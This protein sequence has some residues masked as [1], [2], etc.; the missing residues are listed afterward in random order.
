MIKL[1]DEIASVNNLGDV[2]YD[3]DQ[4]YL[5][6]NEKKQAQE[7]IGDFNDVFK[8]IE[9]VALSNIPIAEKSVRFS[10]D[11]LNYDPTTFVVPGRTMHGT[12]KKL[13]G[14]YA[15]VWDYIVSEGT[16]LESDFARADG[17]P[18]GGALLYNYTGKI[19]ASNL[20]GITDIRSF[21]YG[22]VGLTEVWEFDTSDVV[23]FFRAFSNCKKLK[24][25]P[26]TLNVSSATSANS[27][28]AQL[29][30]NCASL[31][32]GPTLDFGD[33]TAT[34][35]QAHYLF[36]GCTSMT[37][38]E[39][40][41]SHFSVMHG[42]FENDLSLS[43]CKLTNT[44]NV[45]NFKQCFHYCTSLTEVPVKDM[46]AATDVESMYSGYKYTSDTAFTFVVPMHIKAIPSDLIFNS[47]AVN[48]GAMFAG[49]HD[50]T[51]IPN[52]TWP[53]VKECPF[54]F[55]D[56]KNAK[57]GLL[58]T[59]NAL[60]AKLESSSARHVNAFAGCDNSPDIE[61][62]PESWGGNGPEE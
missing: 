35:I 55:Y 2:R 30:R 19:I 22:N 28:M 21:L 7:N 27:G 17:A 57:T 12:W 26:K 50:I 16:S 8:N 38:V 46:S 11:D 44:S 41:C 39:L 9:E 62:I 32:D 45:T 58:S 3:R 60:K 49:C 47:A 61:Y 13:K 53:T 18:N 33:S 10:F 42:A 34:E 20:S 54:I 15:N 52:I 40:D 23:S 4:K 59:Y 29:F 5:T 25:F 37:N 31:V 24:K 51:H 56:N 6:Q 14:Q 43:D 1:Y 48:I 36:A